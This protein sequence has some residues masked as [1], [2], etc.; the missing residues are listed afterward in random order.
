MASFNEKLLE[1]V[2]YSM[3]TQR[4]TLSRERQRVLLAEVEASATG[5]ITQA[6][7]DLNTIYQENIVEAIAKLEEAMIEIGML[8]TGCEDE[9]KKLLQ[10]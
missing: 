5:T 3:K 2:F 10:S 7:L 9:L 8:F 4:D 6:Q 1:G